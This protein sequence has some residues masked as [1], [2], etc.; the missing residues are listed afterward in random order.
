MSNTI[1]PAHLEQLKEEWFLKSEPGKFIDRQSSCINSIS[2]YYR[3]IEGEELDIE[4]LREYLTA[5]HN[6]TNG[7]IDA[8]AL[9]KVAEILKVDYERLKAPHRGEQQNTK[10]ASKTAS[11]VVGDDADGKTTLAITPTMK[12]ILTACRREH[13]KGETLANKV[14]LEYN[15]ARKLFAKLVKAGK[16]RNDPAHGYRTV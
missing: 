1:P 3:K 6:M 15:Y 2:R 7:E 8:C 5:E 10:A 12:K 13:L 4:R 14:G 9:E 16:L 11:Q